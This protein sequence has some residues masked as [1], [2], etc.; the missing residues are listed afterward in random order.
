[1]GVW[2]AFPASDVLSTLVTA[3]F[4]QK[5]IKNNLKES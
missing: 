5:E 3:Y 1:L 4:L 2:M